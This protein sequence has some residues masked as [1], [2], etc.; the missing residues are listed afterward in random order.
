M[1]GVMWGGG[2]KGSRRPRWP[3]R[4]SS[5]SGV[6]GWWV[7]GAAAGVVGATAVVGP[8]VAARSRYVRLRWRVDVHTRCRLGIGHVD[9]G[10]AVA[11]QAKWTGEQV[12]GDHSQP[13]QDDQHRDQVDARGSTAIAWYLFTGPL[14][15]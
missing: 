4:A 2:A 14:R 3:R 11:A 12:P 10:R 7:V 1:W 9:V 5:E 15:L 6:R 13:R 8:C